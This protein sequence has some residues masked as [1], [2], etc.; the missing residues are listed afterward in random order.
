MSKITLEQVIQKSV[1]HFLVDKRGPGMDLNGDCVYCNSKGQRCAI[2]ILLPKR[3]ATRIA[4]PIGNVMTE[5]KEVRERLGHLPHLTSL[6]KCHD[7]A[8][9]VGDGWPFE[10]L[11]ATSLRQFCID[12][13]IPMPKEL[14]EYTNV[15]S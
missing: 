15:T 4:G 14:E 7:D 3:L 1:K 12:H 2:G 9:L 13:R 8:A 5:E 11:Y 10:N 6:Q